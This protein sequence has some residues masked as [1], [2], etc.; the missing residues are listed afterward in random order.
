MTGSPR[1]NGP[2]AYTGQRTLGAANLCRLDGDHTGTPQRGALVFVRRDA[3][4]T[5]PMR[6]VLVERVERGDT[7]DARLRDWPR[8][9]WAV[10][11]E[12]PLR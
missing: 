11:P 12:R 6:M 10:R 4:D 1:S 9:I 5:D 8:S 2:Y 7:Y 3:D